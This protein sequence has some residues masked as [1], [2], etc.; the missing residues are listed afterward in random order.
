MRTTILTT[1]IQIGRCATYGTVTADVGQ[2]PSRH[3]ADD[4][5]S[6]GAVA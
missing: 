1:A 2:F 6:A 4:T 3:T 5:H